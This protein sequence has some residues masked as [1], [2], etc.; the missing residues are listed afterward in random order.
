MI[1]SIMF[2]VFVQ[3]F[4]RFRFACKHTSQTGFAK[5]SQKLNQL[6]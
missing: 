1:E 2:V 3:I 5:G 4:L 6:D